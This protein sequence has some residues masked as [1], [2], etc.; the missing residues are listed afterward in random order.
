MENTFDIKNGT[1]LHCLVKQPHVE[2]PEGVRTIASYAFS[3]PDNDLNGQ[4]KL[5]SVVIP[6]SVTMIKEKAFYDCKRLETVMVLGPA[7]IG[8]EAFFGCKSLYSVHLADGVRALNTECFSYCENL[9]SLFI[10]ASV[11][12]IGIDI[13]CQNDWD[14]E[15]PFFFC[16]RKGKAKEWSPCWNRIYRDPRYNDEY[17]TYYHRVFYGLT[18]SG[19]SREAMEWAHPSKPSTIPEPPK[20]G[21]ETIQRCEEALK[22]MYRHQWAY[23]LDLIYVPQIPQDKEHIR[24]F[25]MYY[26]NCTINRLRDD[27]IERLREESNNPDNATAC[28]LYGYWLVWNARGFKDMRRAEEL[29]RTAAE[30]GFGIMWWLLRYMWKYGQNSEARIDKDK[31]KFFEEKA[32]PYDLDIVFTNETIGSLLYGNDADPKKALELVR[33]RIEDA[34]GE[35]KANDAIMVSL[36]ECLLANGDRKGAIVAAEKAIERGSLNS[37]Y[38]ALVMAKCIN[39]AGDDWLK[40]GEDL[41]QNIFDRAAKDGSSYGLYNQAIRL[42]DHA[43][44]WSRERKKMLQIEARI[45]F[46]KAAIL[47]HGDACLELATC[48]NSGEL[49]FYGERAEDSYPFFLRGA[50]AGNKDCAY[51]L[52]KYQSIALDNDIDIKER[53]VNLP[54]DADHSSPAAWRRYAEVLYESEGEAW[55]VDSDE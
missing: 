39:D 41:A 21:K 15:N 26:N 30:A 22:L 27:Q 12:R 9:R 25:E 14:Y 17:H 8:Y 34:G 46:E 10:P 50:I 42:H 45:A 19:F 4:K 51:W 53:E 16:E 37:G 5:V 1:L 29:V 24:L 13:A 43:K 31:V 47:S 35:D 55:P 20:P 3:E 48:A 49:A 33:Q 44:N 52:Y 23:A 18:R 32:L 6:K 7:E 2:I 36:S 28:F 40:G 38:S 11:E 54:P